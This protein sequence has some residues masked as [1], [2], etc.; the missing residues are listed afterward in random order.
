MT[1]D[2]AFKLA[3]NFA[4]QNQFDQSISILQQLLT[5]VPDHPDVVRA[6]GITMLKKGD[7][8]EA[9]PF[10]WKH[11]QRAWAADAIRELA[12]TLEKLKR[13]G[14]A[15]FVCRQAGPQRTA[16][17]PYLLN[18][19]GKSLNHL[20]R[21]P[22]ALEKFQQARILAPDEKS[23]AR[24]ISISLLG[25]G[26]D[27]KAIQCFSETT[28]P[29]S[30]AGEAKDIV[31]LYAGE[32]PSYDDNEVQR[33]LPE[34]LVDFVREV[35]PNH[36][37]EAALDLACGTG[38]LADH[39][40]QENIAL[41]GIDLSPDML[42][43]AARKG[44]YRSLIQG[45]MVAAMAGLNESFDTVFACACLNYLSDLQ[46]LF[47]NVARALNPGG[48]FAFSVDPSL[49]SQDIGVTAPGEYCHSRKYLRR[50]AA[51]VGFEE[52]AITIGRHRGT[53]GFWCVFRKMPN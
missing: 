43:G 7:L 1:F 26:E 2:E 41:V 19:W 33:F 31:N 37:I 9:V 47:A 36:R 53:P 39:L 49:D 38:L 24:N 48:I 34:R 27:E 8:A 51:E 21:F 11:V 6:L 35:V 50:L 3:A 15:D 10:L 12:F 14:D 52:A 22:E 28:A 4:G 23:I 30:G 46:P 32:A 17:D 40:P 18:I 25:C 16:A 45:D 44:R 5:A 29:W 13:Y 42:A 20:S